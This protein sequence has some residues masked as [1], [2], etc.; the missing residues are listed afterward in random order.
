M[1]YAPHI[2][3]TLS[4]VFASSSDE[5]KVDEI[6]ATSLNLDPGGTG[7]LPD[8]DLQTYLSE[9]Q[10]GMADLWTGSGTQGKVLFDAGVYLQQLKV[11]NIA[12]TGKVVPYSAYHNY[13]GVHHTGALSDIPPV[14]CLA[15]SFNSNQ[16]RPPGKWGRMFLPNRYLCATG[17]GWVT[18]TVQDAIRRWGQDLLTLVQNSGGTHAMT[19]VVASAVTVTNYPVTSVLVGSRTDLISRRHNKQSETYSVLPWA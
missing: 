11:A 19:P 16:P 12:A 5:G 1:V 10:S 7:N 3:M 13:T 2:K 17:T 6:F 14:N 18:S 9:I 4:G 8:A 15:L